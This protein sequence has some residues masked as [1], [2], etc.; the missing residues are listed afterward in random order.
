[1]ACAWGNITSE[2]KSAAYIHVHICNS[3]R[4]IKKATYSIVLPVVKIVGT[5]IIIKPIQPSEMIIIC[6][7]M[8][9]LCHK[10]GKRKEEGTLKINITCGL[11][12]L[13]PNVEQ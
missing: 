13:F 8:C 10:C 2:F 7:L 6:R 9:F 3:F 12:F 1:M 4:I 5:H 11:H